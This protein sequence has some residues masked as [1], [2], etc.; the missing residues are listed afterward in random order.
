[1]VRIQFQ[2]GTL[3]LT[4]SESE[5][6]PVRAWC[7]FD[8]RIDCWR[9]ESLHYAQIVLT[10]RAGGIPYQDEARDFQ[11]IDLALDAELAPRPYQGEAVAAWEEASR[12]GV[13]VLPT[14]SGKSFV[15][16]LVISRTR[17]PAL[18]VV[19]TLDLMAQW[20]SQLERAFERP[21]GLLGGGN[22]DVRELTVSTYDSA[23]LCMEFI[24][25][26]FGLL[27]VDEC[28]HLPG[29]VNRNL[30]RMSLAPFRLGLTATPERDDSEDDLYVDL[31]GKICYRKEIDELEGNV[32]APYRTERVS[33]ELEPDE[34]EAYS[35]H[36]QAYV[37]FIR[38]H[39]I[40]FGSPTGWSRFLM[41]CARDV[42]GREVFRSYLEQRRIARTARAK[43]QHIWELFRA[44]RGERVLVFTADN[45]TAYEIGRRFLLPVITH[46]TKLAERRAFLD[47]FREGA[48]PVLVTSKVLNEG[49]D[50]PEASVGIVVSG[51]GSTREHVQRLGRI[52]RPAAG[53]QAVL[54]E[55]VS[56][57]TSESNTSERRRQHRAYQRPRPMP[58]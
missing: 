12:R 35:R 51:S 55:L 15:A 57:G 46:H 4:G 58:H 28:H 7:V 8:D 23:V 53:K 3:V 1:M 44:H 14:G 24:G 56:E 13:I 10:L 25:N 43:F 11:P 9:A 34:A 47:A 17:R 40:N 33:L 32:L 20:A 16:R 21:I 18:I 54:Y 37:S 5:L 49:V 2:Q 52:L 48:Y 36:R 39:A 45:D 29:A 22:R 50:V 38:A 19:P 30:A 6:E 27:V 26:R 31:L 41:L 42:G